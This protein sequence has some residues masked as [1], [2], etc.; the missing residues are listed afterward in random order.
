[1]PPLSPLLALRAEEMAKALFLSPEAHQRL[2]RTEKVWRYRAYEGGEPAGMI[3]WQQS[4]RGD[5]I[6]VRESEPFTMRPIFLWAQPTWPDQAH[7]DHNAL[8]L[9]TLG[10]M[11]LKAER[12]IGWLDEHRQKTQTARVMQGLFERNLL[13]PSENVPGDPPEA[14]ELK[15]ITLLISGDLGAAPPSWL[16]R[17]RSHAARGSTGLLLDYGDT[18]DSPLHQ[19]ARTMGWPIIKTTPATPPEQPLLHLFEEALKASI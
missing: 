5:R 14:P 17:M 1:M 16:K 19:T 6:I 15:F 10:H 2:G 13:T 8:L 11:L 18:A 9:M 12:S 4:A 7:A 3:D